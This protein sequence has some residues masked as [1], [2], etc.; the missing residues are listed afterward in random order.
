MMTRLAIF[1]F[2]LLA[3]P[4]AGFL[5][6]GGSW[7]ELA[8]ISPPAADDTAA[9]VITLLTLLCYVL[10]TNLIVTLRLRSNPFAQQRSFFL[11]L[12]VASAGLGWLLSYLNVYT[13]SWITAAD[14]SLLLLL[15]QTVLF[16]LL[17]PAILST[18]AVF[19]LFSGLLKYLARAPALPV[20]PD[21]TL[22]FILVPVAGL[23]LMGGAA[24]PTQL[25]WLLWSAPLLLLSALQLFWRESTIFAGLKS[26]DWGRVICAALSGVIVGNL[27]VYSFQAAGGSLTIN[28][29]H[30]LFVHLGFAV[31]GLLCLQLGDVIAE[32]WRGK[33]RSELF[34][35]KK[36]F[37]IPI[38]TKKK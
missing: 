19:G 27:A 36:K 35:Q 23:G 13:A 6:G 24:W 20:F 11:A 30:P 7:N 8:G 32:Q 28:L 2:A 21:E 29:A 37:P 25:S 38:V 1:A 17:A 16:G 12:G 15:F 5:L 3:L 26:G 9:A 22:V 18:R 33:Q 4:A 31:F 14:N 34:Q 10:A